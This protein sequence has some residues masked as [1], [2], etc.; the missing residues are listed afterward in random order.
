MVVNY[1]FEAAERFPNIKI[2]YMWKN[3]ITLTGCGGKGESQKEP[4]KEKHGETK[5]FYVYFTTHF[6]VIY[7]MFIV[8]PF[9]DKSMTRDTLSQG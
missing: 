8:L 9:L 3:S 5:P 6:L 2:E 4:V 7:Y 1:L